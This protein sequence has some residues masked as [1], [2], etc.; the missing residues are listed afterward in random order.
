MKKENVSHC[1]HC[2]DCTVSNL[3]SSMRFVGAFGIQLISHLI[4]IY[5]MIIVLNFVQVKILTF[6][7]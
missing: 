2:F 1:Y 5:D 4:N 3:F 7:L 6:V